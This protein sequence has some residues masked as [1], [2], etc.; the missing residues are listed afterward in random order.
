M[1]QNI[2]HSANVEIYPRLLDIQVM[3]SMIWTMLQDSGE[4]RRRKEYEGRN[5]RK[6]EEEEIRGNRT[7]SLWSPQTASESDCFLQKCGRALWSLLPSCW[8]PPLPNSQYLGI[9]GIL[10]S[11]GSYPGESSLRYGWVKCNENLWLDKGSGKKAK[12][13]QSNRPQPLNLVLSLC[14][15]ILSSWLT[16]PAHYWAPF[17]TSP[18]N[19][20]LN[21]PERSYIIKGCLNNMFTIKNKTKQKQWVPT[22]DRTRDLKICNL[23]LYRWAI[24]TICTSQGCLVLYLTGLLYTKI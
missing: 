11:Y 15:Y 3:M 13:L 10:W 4:G 17:A 1:E 16:C 21:I 8:V 6:W 12:C 20:K 5:R 18:W 9:D 2:W 23:A 14:R 19:N 22:K 24:E 7:G